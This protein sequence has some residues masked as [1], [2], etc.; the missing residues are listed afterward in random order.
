MAKKGEGGRAGRAPVRGPGRANKA[1]CSKT[2]RR[3]RRS[4]QWLAR[5]LNDPYVSS[6]P[7]G[8]PLACRLQAD[9]VDDRVP[10]AAPAGRRRSGSAPGGWTQVRVERV[11]RRRAAAPS[12][13]WTS[14]ALDP[15]PGATIIALDFLDRRRPAASKRRS[16]PCRSVLSDMAAPTTGMARQIIS[17][18]SPSP[19]P[20][21]T[22][23][24]RCW[25]RAAAFLC[26]VSRRTE[27]ALLAALKRDFTSAA[28]PSPGRAAANRP[29][30]T[31]WR[32]GFAGQSA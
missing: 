22:S 19:R 5:Q 4:T 9:A 10:P 16:R 24:V 2:A 15:V 6:A 18:S 1:C 20:A 30:S 29:S 14:W 25:R 26:K 32:R 31:S 8:L 7:L 28:T 27:A 17:A 13:A 11:G 23:P 12:S 3:R 21:S